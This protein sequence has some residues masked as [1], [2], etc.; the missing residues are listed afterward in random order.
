MVVVCVASF[1]VLDNLELIDA[2]TISINGVIH[3]KVIKILWDTS[4]HKSG[5]IVE[6]WLLE[7]SE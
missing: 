6:N 3:I 7:P 4:L 5:K 1:S 2:K